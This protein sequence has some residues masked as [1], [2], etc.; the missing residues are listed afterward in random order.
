M[1][2]VKSVVLAVCALTVFGL[3]SAVFAQEA[4]I[5]LGPA[6]FDSGLPVE[7]TSDSLNVQQESSTAVFVGN[8]KAVQGDMRLA[9]ERILVKYDQNAGSIEFIEAT[10]NV[11]F[12]NGTEVAE[13]N[14]GVYRLGAGT[15]VLTG[16]VLLL[17]G[18]NAIS[19]DAL[20]L[21]LNTN[22]GSMRGNVKT[23]F[24]PKNDQ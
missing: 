1:A 3:V 12:T 11:V 18:Q 10:Q 15:I 5:S 20:T 13:A 21:D 22:R 4:S 24:V 14:K 2:I 6:T 16:N 23:I 7:V 19:G 8:A 9:A 17:Q